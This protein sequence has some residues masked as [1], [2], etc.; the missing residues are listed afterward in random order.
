MN[1]FLNFSALIL[2]IKVLDDVCISIIYV[3]VT[4][5]KYKVQ[6]I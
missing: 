3:T 4:N 6:V 5:I 2:M 1:Q